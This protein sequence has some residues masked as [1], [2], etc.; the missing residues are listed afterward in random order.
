MIVSTKN[1]APFRKEV[2]DIV[3]CYK[4][5][6]ETGVKWTGDY[7]PGGP[8]VPRLGGDRSPEWVAYVE[9]KTEAKAAWLRGWWDGILAKILSETF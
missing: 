7:V 1:Y 4:T 8:W 3:S 5:G 9:K 6:V 2:I